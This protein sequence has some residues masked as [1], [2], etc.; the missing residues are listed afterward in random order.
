MEHPLREASEAAHYHCPNCGGLI[1]ATAG[2]RLII[3][4]HCNEQS[5]I[6][7]ESTQEGESSEQTEPV[8]SAVPREPELSE[9][10][11]K[12]ISNLRRGA[13]RNRS[14]CV[15]AAVLCLVGAAQLVQMTVREARR[16]SVILP[17]GFCLAAAA[18]VLGSGY[19]VRS[20]RLLTREIRASTLPEPAM[21]PDFSTLSDGSQQWR[22]LDEIS[23]AER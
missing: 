10:R 12:Q 21:P 14:W 5:F 2:Q 9:L 1:A 15:V 18:A 13:Y 11:I 16:G 22:N 17:I 6:A 8:K 3:C 4:P 7:D 20:I 23:D 19:F